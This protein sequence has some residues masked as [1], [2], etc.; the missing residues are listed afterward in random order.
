MM[1]KM[2]DYFKPLLDKLGD[3]NTMEGIGKLIPRLFELGLA[4]KAV[5]IGAKGLS[6]VSKVLVYL[7]N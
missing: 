6:V 7:A 2:F 4:L 3:G 5:S 1:Q